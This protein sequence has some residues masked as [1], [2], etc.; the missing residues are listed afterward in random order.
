MCDRPCDSSDGAGSPRYCAFD[1]CEFF[2]FRAND[3]EFAEVG[4][5]GADHSAVS[6]VRRLLHVLRV[7]LEWANAG[8]ALVE[9]ESHS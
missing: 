6:R 2:V 9:V 8:Q 1:R 7:D 5:R 3:G 4:D